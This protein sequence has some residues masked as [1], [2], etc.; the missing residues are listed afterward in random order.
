MILALGRLSRVRVSWAE[1]VA[2][3]AHWLDRGGSLM[4]LKQQVTCRKRRP[5]Q[6]IVLFAVFIVSGAFG[7]GRCPSAIIGLDICRTSVPL[8]SEP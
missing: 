4:S 2:L 7:Q 6:S 3:L 1:V 5:Q 8:Q